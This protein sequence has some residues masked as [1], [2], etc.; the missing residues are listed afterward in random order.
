MNARGPISA[1]AF[2]G[3][4]SWLLP[5]IVVFLLTP[6]LLNLLG[7][8]RFGMLMI[9][10]V[11]PVI[12]T[13]LDFGVAASAVR[14][15][16][17][18]LSQGQVDGPGTIP[19]YAVA[20]CAIASLFGTVVASA[21]GWLADTLGVTDLLGSEAAQ[22]LIRWCAVWGAVSLATAVPALVARAAQSF[23]WLTAAQ[24]IATVV[25]WI[26]ALLLSRAGHP[27]RDIVVLGILVTAA[28][29]ALMTFA[30][31]RMVRWDSP[32]LF[33]VS[34]PAR[35]IHF[36]GGMFIAQ[37]ASAIAY[38]ADRILI[39][40][41][42][43][44]AVAG[45]YALCANVANKPLAAVVAITSFAF[46]HASGLHLSGARDELR[47]LLHS[48][49]RAVAVLVI[50]L[51]VPALG[52][53]QPFLKLWLGDY[54][55]PDL[56]RA[57]Q[58]LVI[59]FAIPAFAVPVGHVLAASGRSG[60]AA[61]FSWLTAGVVVGGIIAL[62]PPYGLRGAVLAV[63]AAMSTSLIFSV[64]ARRALALQKPERQLRLRAGIA[65]GVTAQVV[66]LFSLTK[67]VNDWRTLFLIGAS[68]WA[69]F[70][71]VR[72]IFQT[73]SP[74]EI[75]LLARLRKAISLPSWKH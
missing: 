38:Q 32:L 15:L 4:A 62:V 19:F 60:L 41:F 2:W 39:S 71:L 36:A 55:T 57:F 29:A 64:F 53:A 18:D 30:V 75:R 24:T 14:R 48:L 28:S 12:A 5:L 9:V 49:D 1:Q 35:D 52:L 59:A 47:A 6:R 74:E 20:F 66:V 34:I 13:Q 69:A 40:S 56:A 43:S 72:V 17:A 10:L 21:S 37:I 54:G 70:F 63:L 65:L 67:F 68:S 51:L 31:H 42:A 33:K 23:V 58:V 45:A 61:R 50:P 22:E 3:L 26:G 27:L 46:P 8:E 11:T 16:A 25:L 44:P 7:A 73:L